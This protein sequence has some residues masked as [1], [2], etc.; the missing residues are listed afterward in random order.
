MS[1]AKKTSGVPFCET[2]RVNVPKHETGTRKKKGDVVIP[3]EL[4]NEI[5]NKINQ[6][7]DSNTRLLWVG[8]SF[9]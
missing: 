1:K 6:L 7:D 2:F 8:F 4:Q 3:I 9:K 5:H